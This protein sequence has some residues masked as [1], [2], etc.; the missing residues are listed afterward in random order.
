[1]SQPQVAVVGGGLAGLSAAVACADA[2]SC[3]TLFESRTRLGGATWSVQRDG[4]WLDNGQHV[5][6][7]CC[8][9]YLA[10][11]R[12]LGVEGD[13]SIQERLA[14]PVL[15]PDRAPATLQRSD[16][17]A[18]FHLTRS[19]LQFHHVSLRERVRIGRT[20]LALR[21]L[22]PSD[23]RLDAQSFG[24]WLRAHGESADALARFWD[25]FAR[26]TL[27]AP[28]EA[29]SLALA[30]KVFRTGL[31]EDARAGD[32]GISA[33]PLSHLHADPAAHALEALGA[34]IF[35]RTP[36]EAVELSAGGQLSIRSRGRQLAVDAVIVAT[37]H[38]VAATLVPAQAAVDGDA[39]R[40]LGSSPI[41]NLHVVYDRR[42]TDHAFAAGVGT[43]VQWLF[44][45]TQSAGLASGQCLAVSLSAADEWVGASRESLRRT[46]E[47][48]LARLLP[49][50][51]GAQVEAFYVTC[52]RAATFRQVAGTA[53]LR[54]GAETAAP[55]VFLAGAWTDTGWPATMEGAVR[56][57][58]RAA[59]AALL[60]AGVRRGLPDAVAA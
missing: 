49:G 39:L 31:L 5:F 14:I 38:D 21:R 52:E 24:Q 32:I 37:P 1:M 15:M 54:P 59:R 4:L 51:R 27:N 23:R 16:W 6:L 13:V 12:R 42:V 2:G 34:D 29:A 9:A 40:A 3:V 58:Q 56:S 45:R 53:A 17:P 33:V 36:V 10:F 7:R 30:V 35:V 28:V 47:P 19:L 25:L 26:A 11:L 50:A 18:P 57:G 48:E 46:F 55:G 20:A 43:P 41:V 22:E 8:D 44:D 60:H